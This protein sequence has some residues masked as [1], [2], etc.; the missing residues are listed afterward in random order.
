M[1]YQLYVLVLYMCVSVQD[2]ALSS[3]LQNRIP[4]RGDPH[5]LIVGDP[6]LGKSQML[7]AA[8]SVAPRS[9]YVCGNT[10][11]TS[12]LTVSGLSCCQLF[13]FCLHYREQMALYLGIETL[14][15]SNLTFI[16]RIFFFFIQAVVTLLLGHMFHVVV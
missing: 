9:V 8:A 6:G 3:F 13:I 16:Y 7:Q 10:T 14:S 11:T 5:I 1:L 2:G 15:L 4:V 12:G